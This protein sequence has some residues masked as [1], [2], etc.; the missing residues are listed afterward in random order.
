MEKG[1]EQPQS[2]VHQFN[3]LPQELRPTEK[4]KSRLL[5]DSLITLVPAI[6]MVIASCGGATPPTT[7]STTEQT[8]PPTEGT[9]T[10]PTDGTPEP[11]SPSPTEPP[12]E[13]TT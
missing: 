13:T 11:T 3:L 12:P 6:A 5:P 2:H 9:T 10:L 8:V 4:P 1:I 7:P